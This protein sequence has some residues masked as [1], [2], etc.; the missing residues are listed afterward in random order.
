MSMQ[1]V[2][3]AEQAL[4]EL[5]ERFCHW[6]QNRAHTHARIPVPLWDQA[7]ALSRVLPNGQVAKVRSTGWKLD[8]GFRG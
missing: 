8:R 4:A 2:S 3:Q 5:A 1:T 6:R 7:V